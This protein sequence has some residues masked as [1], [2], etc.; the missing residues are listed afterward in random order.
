MKTQQRAFVV[1]IKSAR[2]RPNVKKNAIWGSTDLKALVREAEAEV[3][4]LFDPNADSTAQSRDSVLLPNSGPAVHLEDKTET[5]DDRKFSG[6]LAEAEQSCL[7]QQVDVPA[8]SQMSELEGGRPG[9]GSPRVSR[10]R[11][12]ADA[13]AHTQSAKDPAIVRSTAAQV[14]VPSD[15][16]IRLEGEN[17]RLKAL[18]ASHL[19]QQ[20]MQLREMLERLGGI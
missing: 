16:L 4:H 9:R 8:Q 17:R 1:E 2:R 20:N 7:L 18:L 6:S 12:D 14:E 15:D 10:R 19:R 11:R 3:P 5:I 13:V